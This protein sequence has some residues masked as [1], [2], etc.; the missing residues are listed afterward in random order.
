MV[1]VT[2]IIIH[3]YHC[4]SSRTATLIIS[5]NFQFPRTQLLG[6]VV[7]GGRVSGGGPFPSVDRRK[8]M[9]MKLHH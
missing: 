6:F 2:H 8:Q 5:P 3:Y 7:G 4:S 9:Q 1:A